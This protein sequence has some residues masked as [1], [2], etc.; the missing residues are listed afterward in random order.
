MINRALKDY[1][2]EK[3]DKDKNY[4]KIL[5]KVDNKKIT[6]NT[7]LKYSMAT[8]CLVFMIAIG[9]KINSKYFMTKRGEEIS[10][11]EEI[12]QD[13]IIKINNTAIQ[14]EALDIDAK[15]V[16]KDLKK[17]FDF[18]KDMYIPDYCTEESG[19]G[20]IYVRE[21][22]EDDAY[23]KL[24]QYSVSYYTSGGEYKEDSFI[25]IEFSKNK[26]LH[27]LYYDMEEVEESI[28]NNVPVKIFAYEEK[29]DK[30]KIIPNRPKA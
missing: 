6:H 9:A 25:D 1:T 14:S 8:I 11:Q 29:Q 13:D 20:E 3:F 2:E 23:S 10:K 17:E 18:I 4:E 5:R 30:S 7:I 27:C 16:E 21:N 15:F 24:Y 19:Q 22:I 12:V 28:I 26:I